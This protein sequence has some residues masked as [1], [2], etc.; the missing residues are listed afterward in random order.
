MRPPKTI[1][2]C[3]LALLL[4]QTTGC[5]SFRPLQGSLPR[6]R[7]ESRKVRRDIRVTKRDGEE[8]KLKAAWR[9]QERVGGITRGP[10]R[11]YL[12]IPLTEVV[13]L[14]EQYFN[15]TRTLTILVL[16]LP[17]VLAAA[18]VVSLEDVE[19]LGGS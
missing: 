8:V 2:V 11:E 10:R 13:G 14:E 7:E 18:G 19:F 3:A 9:D 15:T 17:F 6:T 12:E 5:Y 4:V 16:G 1:T